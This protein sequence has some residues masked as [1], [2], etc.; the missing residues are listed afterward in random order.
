[1]KNDSYSA[2]KNSKELSNEES[3]ALQELKSYGFRL[4]RIYEE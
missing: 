2:M 4:L 1:M 3:G